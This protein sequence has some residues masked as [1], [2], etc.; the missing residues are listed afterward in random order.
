MDIEFSLFSLMGYRERGKNLGSIVSDTISLVKHAEEVGF[1]AAWFAEH[2]FSNYCVCPSPLLMVSHC[3]GVTSK[4]KLGPAVLVVPL[5]QPIRLIEDI[6]LISELCGDRFILGIGS[7][8]QPYEFERFGKELSLAKA[9]LSEFIKLMDEAFGN[10]TFSFNGNFT[11]VPETSVSTRPVR[12][13]P[14]WIAGDSEETH[15]L[16]ARRGFTPII[17][18]R[19]SGPDYLASMRSRIDSSYISEGFSKGAESL[20]I[21]RF[22]CI[23]ENDVE[24]EN[25]LEN[26]RYQLR[27]A[28]ALRNREEAM[29]A[30]MMVEQPFSNEPTL[31]EMANNL[32]VGSV[33]TVA[34]RL[35][36]DIRASGANHIMLNIQAG[37]STL[38]QA[39]RTMDALPEIRSAIAEDLV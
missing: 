37:S 11:K 31:N 26:V 36:K 18:G 8:Y 9:E 1:D 7:G 6:G 12:K 35:R 32:A 10:E 28:M 30:G 38:D 33:E 13:P 20:G 16:A 29:D 34:T 25:Y 21:L 22:A 19:S 17:T 15:K 39:K 4:I 24:T 27:L 23:T 2:H 5:Y 3:I 14:I